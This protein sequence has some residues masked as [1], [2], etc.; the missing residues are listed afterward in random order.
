[1]RSDP[2]E[3]ERGNR[4]QRPAPKEPDL[5]ETPAQPPRPEKSE[6]EKRKDKA[7]EKHEKSGRAPLIR[8]LRKKLREL[9]SLR[10]SNFLPGARAQVFVTADD[11]V[12]ILRESNVVPQNEDGSDEHRNWMG[13]VFKEAGWRYVGRSVPSL[14]KELNGRHVRCWRWEGA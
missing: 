4:R 2:G 5:W 14:R 6:G 9:Q 13:S 10:E 11:A 12:K 3:Q 1:M 8:F 7:L